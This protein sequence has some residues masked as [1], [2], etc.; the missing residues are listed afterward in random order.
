MAYTNLGEYEQAGEYL[1]TAIDIFKR[2]NLNH[3]VSKVKQMANS[4]EI[5]V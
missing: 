3:M 2:L 1:K 5:Q 4:V